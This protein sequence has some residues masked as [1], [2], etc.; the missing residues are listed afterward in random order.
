MLLQGLL[1]VVE[2]AVW[3]V[4]HRRVKPHGQGGAVDTA[5][6]AL[7]QPAGHYTL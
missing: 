1:A 2:Q 6:G 3:Q 7:E 4:E 5:A